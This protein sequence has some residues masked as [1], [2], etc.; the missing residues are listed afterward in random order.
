VCFFYQHGWIYENHPFWDFVV[1]YIPWPALA[2]GFGGLALSLLALSWQRLRPYA[3]AGLFLFGVFALGP[4]LLVNVVL[5]QSWCRPRPNQILE[6]G[7]DQ[8]FVP[9]LSLGN[10]GTAG[11]FPS[12][13][14]AVSFYLF[15]PAFLLYA[16][17]RAWAIVFILLGLVGGFL[18]G[19]GRMA[20]ADHFP[21]DILW[22]AGVVYFSGWLLH[23]FFVSIHVLH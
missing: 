11:S 13:H 20:Q 16:R 18:V 15:V 3:G 23:R 2:F 9:V 10:S 17:H 6:F 1:T 5:K 12:G 22:S 21:S 8:Q 7:G 14:A 4:G 19:I